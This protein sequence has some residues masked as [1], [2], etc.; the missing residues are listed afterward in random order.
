M[1]ARTPILITLV[2]LLSSVPVSAQRLSPKDMAEAKSVHGPLAAGCVGC[3]D[4]H[5]SNAN[6]KY[7]RV[8]TSGGNMQKFCSLCHPSKS[9]KRTNPAEIFSS[10]GETVTRTAPKATKKK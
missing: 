8:N 6:R 2:L 5:P 10:M 4:P 1:R 3:H 7:L 9:G